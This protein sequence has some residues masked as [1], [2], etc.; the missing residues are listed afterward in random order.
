MSV[1]IRDVAKRA[2]VSLGTVSRY[3]NGY[4]LREHNRIRIEEAIRSWV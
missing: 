4:R 1:T 2:N 3:L